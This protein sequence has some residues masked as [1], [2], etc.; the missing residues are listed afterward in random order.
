MILKIAIVDDDM[1]F[2]KKMQKI[3]Q[4]FFKDKKV[5]TTIDIFQSHKLLLYELSE[6]TYY[7]LFLL[8]IET[9]DGDINGMNMA[10]K[11]REVNKSSIL[12]FI[13]S[14]MKYTLEAFKVSTFRYLSK[15][16]LDLELGE[17]LDNVL[18]EFRLR[19]NKF[20]L[21]ETITKYIK[22]YYIDIYYI[23]KVGKY[24]IIVSTIGEYKV[25]KSLNQV[26][27]ELN[28]EEFIFIERGYIAN[29]IHIDRMEK[30]KVYMDND[31]TLKVG[32]PQVHNVKTKIA[33]YWGEHI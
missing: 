6:D 16:N 5:I 17:A 25:R 24:S 2:L 26:Y 11:I 30:E 18:E 3:I 7:D 14:H 23:Y 1:I 20:Y 33:E 31:I 28:S 10:K 12:I 13:T 27:D 21:I 8:D 15:L 32:R 19:E 22:L 4:D 29:I 9:Q